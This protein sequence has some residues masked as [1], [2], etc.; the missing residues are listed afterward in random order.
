MIIYHYTKIETLELILKYKTIRFNR[1]D[2]VDD[3]DEYIHGSGPKDTKLGPYTFVSC[4]TKDRKENTDLWERYTQNKGVRIGLP[5]EMFDTYEFGDGLKSFFKNPMHY[6]Y[7]YLVSPFNNPAKLYD[8][9]YLDEQEDKI[10]ELLIPAGETGAIIETEKVGIYKKREWREQKESRFK[11]NVAPFDATRLK[12]DFS[13]ISDA[14]ID[15]LSL[16]EEKKVNVNDAVEVFI[17][18]VLKRGLLNNYMCEMARLI[19]P[20]IAN[21]Y[22]IKEKYIDM[23]LKNEVLNQIEVM[24]GPHTTAEDMRRVEELLNGFPNHSLIDSKLK[25]SSCGLKAI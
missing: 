12:L 11:I 8:I 24:M 22:E 20:S 14:A 25:R 7:D 21:G 4:W 5:E 15:T 10:K 18:M 6:G 19:G 16:I 3:E 1:L 17:S 23:P 13:G 2:Q 9:E